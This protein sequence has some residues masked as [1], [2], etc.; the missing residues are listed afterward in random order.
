MPLT[1][2]GWCSDTKHR[3]AETRYVVVVAAAT[4]CVVDVQRVVICGLVVIDPFLAICEIAF[5]YIVPLPHLL[6]S[7]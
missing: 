4:E 1:A 6:S 7:I 5:T 2:F 3:Q